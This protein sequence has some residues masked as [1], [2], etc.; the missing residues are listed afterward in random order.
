MASPK[1][2]LFTAALF[3]T[4]SVLASAVCTPISFEI[5]ATAETLAG[6]ET[7]NGT[8]TVGGTFHINGIYCRPPPHIARGSLQILVHGLLYDKSYWHG[9]YNWSHFATSQGYHTLAIDRLGHGQSIEHPDAVE[10]LQLS[11]HVETIHQ[12]V[13][14]IRDDTALGVTFDSI[15]Y[16][17]HSYG[18][19]AG[20]ALAAKYPQDI[21]ILVATGFSN[22]LYA[23]AFAPVFQDLVPARDLSPRFAGLLPGYLSTQNESIREA[24]FYAG[25][26]DPAIA[27]L[28]Y[29]LADT[30]VPGEILTLSVPLTRGFT[31][32]VL[33]VTGA[34]DAGACNPKTGLTCEDILKTTGPL[35]PNSTYR[36]YAPPDTGHDLNF[37]F[38]APKTFQVVHDWLDQLEG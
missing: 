25:A 16:V 10:V 3:L 31:G 7:T 18:T 5:Q 11:L 32:P 9:M 13:A 2:S 15:V 4:H 35:F 30:I 17:G 23:P 21:D 28:D 27:H 8:I 36:F 37:H 26:Y 24:A 22:S 34:D 29:T 14:S 19:G 6:S 33:V 12:V 20:V 38:S 1:L